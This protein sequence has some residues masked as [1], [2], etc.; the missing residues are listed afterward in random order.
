MRDAAPGSVVWVRGYSSALL[1]GAAAAAGPGPR[2]GLGLRRRQLRAPGGAR[3]RQSAARCGARLPRGAALAALRLR[4]HA[5]RSDGLVPGRPRR[6]ALQGAGLPGRRRPARGALAPARAPVAAALRRQRRG[7]AGPAAARRSHAPARGRRGGGEPLGGRR[8]RAAATGSTRP[9]P[10]CASSAACRTPRSRASTCEHDLF[11]APRPRTPLTDLVVP[12]KILE[13]M[14][15]GMPILATDLG[16]VRWMAGEG[17]VFLAPDNAPATLARCI[18]A[19][20]ADPAR[21]AAVGARARERAPRLRLGAH[22]RGDRARGCSRRRQ[23]GR[24]VIGSPGRAGL[25]RPQGSA[26]LRETMPRAPR[27]AC[28]RA[29]PPAGASRVRRRPRIPGSASYEPCLPRARRVRC[30]RLPTPPAE[31]GRAHPAQ[32]RGAGRHQPGGARPRHGVDGRC[33]PATSERSPTAPTSAPRPS[34][35]SSA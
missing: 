2:S 17:G 35:C 27:P 31:R 26:R 3:A 21:L 15:F 13:A 9:R 14:A 32:H 34:C 10:T 5:Q 19:A 7:L 11:V 30:R 24:A 22:R 25:P 23:Q 6:A 33:S 20:L 8:W 1:A 29:L 4:A 18:R 28:P 12:M 16:A